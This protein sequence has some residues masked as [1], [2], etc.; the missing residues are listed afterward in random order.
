MLKTLAYALA[1]SIKVSI[2][3]HHL[4]VMHGNVLPQV[5][6]FQFGISPMVDLTLLGDLSAI[7][8]P[9][10]T[11]DCFGEYFINAAPVLLGGFFD[12]SIQSGFNN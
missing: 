5:L 7:Q 8:F 1:Q 11:T 3:I 2:M 6:G 9:K 4:A 10:V 12:A